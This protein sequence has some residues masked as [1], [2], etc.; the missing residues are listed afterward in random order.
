MF[1]SI[2]VILITNFNPPHNMINY[3]ALLEQLKEYALTLG[4]IDLTISNTIIP[5]NVKVQYA[6]WLQQKFNG[7]MDYLFNNQ[8]LRFNPS[9]LHSATLSIICVKMPYR[10]EDIATYK[11]RL[12][13]SEHAYISS[14]AHGRDYHKVVKQQLNKLAKW[15]NEQLVQANITHTYRAFADS[16]PV[17]EVQLATQSGSGWRGK[18]TLLINKNQGSMFFLGELFTN[19]PLPVTTNDLIKSHCGSCQKCLDICPTN[20]FTAPYVLDARRCI[21][22]LTIENKDSI[23]LELRSKIGN[24]IYGCDDCQI[25]CPWNKFSQPTTLKDFT[26]R[27]NLNDSSLLSLF[28]WNEDEFNL[29]MQGSPIYRIGYLAWI[30]NIAVALGNSPYSE[31]TL[32]ALHDKLQ[33]INDEMVLEHIRWAIA[34]QYT[35]KPQNN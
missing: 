15:L 19:L 2:S 13:E 8:E 20:A 3:D 12:L 33:L 5:D 16:A 29:R 9:Q 7:S 32:S 26:I 4:F 25:F 11:Q 31:L 30:R 18:N 34:E 24:R 28:A 35:K 1:F 6:H 17:L 10:Q 21:S 23:P 14:Y 22:Y 27:N